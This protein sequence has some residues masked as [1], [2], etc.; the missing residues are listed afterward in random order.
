M[1]LIFPERFHKFAEERLRHPDTLTTNILNASLNAWY[2]YYRFLQ[3]LIA[4]YTQTAVAYVEALLQENERI[5]AQAKKADE[6]GQ[7]ATWPVTREELTEMRR[8]AEIALTLH[9]EIESFFVFANILLDRVAS[10]CRYYFWKRADWNH[11]QLTHNLEKVC[12]KKGLHMPDLGLLKMPSELGAKI[13]AYR[14]TRVEHVEEPR[15]HY[16]TMWGPDKKPKIYPILLYPT[17]GEAK[18]MQKPS[19]DIDEIMAL[20]DHYM[21]SM[22]DFFDAN[23]EKSVLPPVRPQA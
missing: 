7:P 2:R 12:A 13:V 20:L 15:L 1:P 18:S 16:A 5:W 6:A 19:G 10:A 8:M 22:L 17:E 21:T 3:I 11:W 4:R 9:L 14:N 23:A